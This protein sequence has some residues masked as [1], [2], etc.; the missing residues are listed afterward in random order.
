MKIGILDYGMANLRSV[1]KAFDHVG[2]P[3]EI[4][5]TPDQV[6]AC[7]RLVLP[8]VGAFADAVAT[9][10][11]AGLDDPIRRHVEHGRPFLGICLGLQMLFDVG[12][13]DGEWKGLGILPGRCVRLD[14]DESMRL[15]VPHMGWNG[16]QVERPS[17]L[18]KGLADNA[19][20]YFVHGYHVEPADRTVVATTT[21]YG[22]PFVSSVW[23]DN[24][25][26][27][28]F[29]PEKSQHVGLAM[30]KNFAEM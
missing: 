14:V 6:N 8:G 19:H 25:V 24:V 20:V 9:L 23:R 17:P 18:M 13:E 28:Q 1:Q 2:H 26:A 22:R 7:D 3:A 21:D 15:K 27:T 16:L 12:L 10:R 29:H 30:L 4:I 5:S 11:A